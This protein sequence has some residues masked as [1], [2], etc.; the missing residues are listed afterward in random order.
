MKKL[1]EVLRGKKKTFNGLHNVILVFG[2]TR[3]WLWNISEIFK[4]LHVSLPPLIYVSVK[5]VGGVI[6]RLL[7]NVLFRPSNLKYNSAKEQLSEANVAQFFALRLLFSHLVHLDDLTPETVTMVKP[8]IMDT[9]AN[10][11]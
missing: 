5:F 1:F 10:S 2:L 6:F 7:T 9:T 3:P 11:H 4:L 8:F